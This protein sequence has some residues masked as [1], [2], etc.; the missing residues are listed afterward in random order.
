MSNSKNGFYGITSNSWL[1]WLALWRL[2]TEYTTRAG[3]LSLSVL[4]SVTF[5]HLTVRI[6]A[7]AACSVRTVKQ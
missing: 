3:A 5:S 1:N 6:F 4:S 7:A 2:R